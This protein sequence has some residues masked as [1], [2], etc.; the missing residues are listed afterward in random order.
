MANGTITLTPFIAYYGETS[1]LKIVGTK[2][3]TPI[4]LPNRLGG[5][6]ADV[7]PG[8]ARLFPNQKV[9]YNSIGQSGGGGHGFNVFAGVAV[10]ES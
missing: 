6:A 4:P 1:D 10:K 2:V 8:L 9:Y 5:S 3:D 7:D